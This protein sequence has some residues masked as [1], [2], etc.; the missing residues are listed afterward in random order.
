[1]NKVSQVL[2]SINWPVACVVAL[3]AVTIVVVALIFRRPIGDAIGRIHKFKATSRGI[4]LI[5]AELEQQTQLPV[6]SRAELSGLS[7]HDVWALNDFANG[8]IPLLVDKMNLQQRVAARTLLDLHLLTI[9]GDGAGRQVAA[10]QLGQQILR[11]ANSL[12]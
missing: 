12:L 5:L 4:E 10:T 6:G 7:A 1:M 2:D 11:A 3:A 9:S 8:R